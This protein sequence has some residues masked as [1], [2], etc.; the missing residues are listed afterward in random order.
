MYRIP[1]ED[2]DPLSNTSF[3]LPTQ[4]T[5]CCVISAV[6]RGS[7]SLLYSLGHFI[8]GLDQRLTL[9]FKTKPLI[10]SPKTGVKPFLG[11]NWCKLWC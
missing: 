6:L 11:L 7:L 1:W 5:I 3:L 2:L 9:K 4:P 8:L 10:Q